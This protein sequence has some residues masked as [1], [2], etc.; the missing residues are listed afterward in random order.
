KIVALASAIRRQLDDRTAFV[1][2][3]RNIAP[4]KFMIELAPAD[5]EQVNSWGREAMADEL[6]AVATDHAT[7]QRYTF[8]G[9]V[10]VDFE[11]NAEL[12]NGRFQVRSETVK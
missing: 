5:E 12:E 11:S 8:V 6:I 2:R 7:R 1:S 10:S 3:E 4:N 9:P